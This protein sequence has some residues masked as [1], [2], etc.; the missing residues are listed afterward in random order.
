MVALQAQVA[1]LVSLHREGFGPPLPPAA[2]SRTQ[3]VAQLAALTAAPP[4]SWQRMASIAAAI[5]LSAISAVVLY[6]Q[7]SE[8]E[9]MS[10]PKPALTPGATVPVTRSDVCLAEER[11]QVRII[12][13]AIQRQVFRE[14]G[15]PDDAPLAYEVDHLITPELGGSDD[16][17]NLWPQ[18]YSDTVWNAHVK[19]ALEDRLHQLV[20]EG[21]VD[22]AR[23]Q[24]DISTDWIAAYKKYF[25]SNRPISE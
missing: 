12:P 23:A 2:S 11:K 14:Y 25:H 1:D 17:R 6:R 4:R 24:Q 8:I 3:L 21:K 5:V 22:L 16:I 19:D 9:A 18:S 15:I 10:V 7:G 20:C 13:A